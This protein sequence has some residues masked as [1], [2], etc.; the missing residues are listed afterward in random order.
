MKKQ[1]EP[2][3]YLIVGTFVA[4][5]IFILYMVVMAFRSDLNMVR[6]DYYE[7]ELRYTEQQQQISQAKSLGNGLQLSYQNHSFIFTIPTDFSEQNIKGSLW[8]YRPSDSKLDFKIDLAEKNIN[9][10]LNL[11]HLQKGKWIVKVDFEY[12]GKHY[13]K[14]QAFII[15]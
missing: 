9:D 11:S 3:P 5:A 12:L 6:K 7:Q 8:F 15:D 13:F 4:F 2:A 14:E 10:S 1:F